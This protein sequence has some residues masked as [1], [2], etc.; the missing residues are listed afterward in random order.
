MGRGL[1]T[2]FAPLGF[3]WQICVALVPGPGR[4]RSG[5]RARWARCTRSRAAPRNVD[6]ALRPMLAS[7][8][9]LATALSLAGLVR[10]R[11][12]MPVD[13]GDRAAR[14]QFLA[15]PAD[16]GRLPVRD[17]VGGLLRHLSDRHGHRAGALECSC[18]SKSSPEFWCI[19]A[20]LY[21]AR[22]LGPRRWRRKKGG[23]GDKSGRRRLVRLRQGRGRLPLSGGQPLRGRLSTVAPHIKVAFPFI[24]PS[25]QHPFQLPFNRD[26][27]ARPPSHRRAW[28]CAFICAWPGRRR[29]LGRHRRA[30][31]AQV[32]IRG[33]EI[34]RARARR[35]PAAWTGWPV[36]RAIR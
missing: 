14:N 27:P 3:N 18:G 23:A 6:Q 31:K 1:H 13:A 4:A 17:G 2:I 29:A 15:L 34:P 11:T 10:V 28:L 32:R 30:R 12:A 22:A 33:A 26:S 5:G 35:S 8:W 20:A 9:S 7:S 36:C 21:A 19:A 25:V 16:H 24:F